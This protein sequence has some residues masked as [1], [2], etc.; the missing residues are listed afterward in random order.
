MS[1]K[2][3]KSIVLASS[4]ATVSSTQA[5]IPEQLTEHL[6]ITKNWVNDLISNPNIIKLL[7]EQINLSEDL[8]MEQKE[9]LIKII[10]DEKNFFELYKIIQEEKEKWKTIDQ[11]II[12]ITNLLIGGIIWFA[13]WGKKNKLVSNKEKLSMEERPKDKLTWAYNR[14]SF[15][16][17]KKEKINSTRRW[18]PFIVASLDLDFFKQVNDKFWH[19][20]WDFV[21]KKL[22]ETFN[23]NIRTDD[24]DKDC[25]YRIWWDEFIVV[26]Q[27]YDVEWVI[28][29][30]NKIKKI[31]IDEIKKY[32]VEH[33]IDIKIWVSVGLKLLQFKSKPRELSE[34][35][36][37]KYK[38]EKEEKFEKSLKEIDEALYVSKFIHLIQDELW[39]NIKELKNAVV[40]Y[41]YDEHWVFLW[42]NYYNID[43]FHISISPEN[44]NLIKTKRKTNK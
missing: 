43:W 41:K 34:R 13:Y 3:L 1:S 35:D 29:T 21:L 2:L 16:M 23:L 30:I 38:K 31:F 8:S 26:F 9:E 15:D 25:I 33:K 17:F 27:S 42:A 4:L 7:E 37:P 32:S 28:F 22:V 40:Y 20:V 6:N 12:I 19:E 5:K 24:V 44:L 10:K 39:I 11:I 14:E 36:L 18:S